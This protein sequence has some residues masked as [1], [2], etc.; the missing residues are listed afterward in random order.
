MFDLVISLQ[1]LK[2]LKLN[3]LINIEYQ[4]KSNSVAEG[5]TVFLNMDHKHGLYSIFHA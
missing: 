4:Y 5:Y 1:F 3:R 2:N